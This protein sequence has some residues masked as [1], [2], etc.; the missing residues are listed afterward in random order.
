VFDLGGVFIELGGVACMLEL[1]DHRI[2]VDEL[3]ARWIASPSVRAFETGRM[4]ADRFAAVLL[5]EFELA[6][7]PAAF[8]AEF[9]AWPT[10]PYPGSIELLQSLAPHYTLAYVTNTN[11]LHWP[12]MHDEMQLAPQFAMHV[13]SHLL[14]LLKP[15]R[16]IFAHVVERLGY[17]PERILFLDDT[18]VNVERARSVGI[19]AYRV[20]GLEGVIEL[21]HEVP[22][23][24]LL[25]A[26]A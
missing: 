1:L 19:S 5:A 3:W 21:L 7:D 18:A 9:T 12:R 22:V 14:G 11:A 24:P 8:L 4:E 13:A 16:A 26:C 2:T 25:S 23:L 15:D 10:G 17:T 20:I 6:I